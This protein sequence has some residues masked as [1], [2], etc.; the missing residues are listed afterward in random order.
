LGIN[1]AAG[2]ST[3]CSGTLIGGGEWILTAAHCVDRPT[4]S[5]AFLRDSSFGFV[6]QIIIHPDWQRNDFLGGGDI[7][8]LRLS[9]P[10]T[11]IEA[12]QIY[13]GRNELGAVGTSVGFGRTGTGL[14]GQQQGT[15]GTL[16]GGNNVLDVLGTARG[17]DPRILLTDFDNPL[18]PNDS[19][20][21]SNLPLD[22]EYSIGPGDSGGGLFIFTDDGWQIAGISSFVNSTDGNPDGDYGDSNGFTRVSDY[23]GW[24]NSIVPAPSTLPMLA[25]G[26]LF[27][28][29]RRR[30]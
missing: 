30:R 12:A 25:G 15:F 29:R 22:L 24:I 28:A 3:D 16:R 9:S 17:W 14:T 19:N 20:Y 10:I 1:F 13:T 21:G 7:A 6:D 2:G 27:G 23:A 26:L 18:N 4:S 8:L 5:V 11:S